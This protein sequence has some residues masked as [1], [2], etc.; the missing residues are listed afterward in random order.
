MAYEN[1]MAKP[2]E[3]LEA[4]YTEAVGKPTGEQVS[5]VINLTQSLTGETM[6]ETDKILH[7]VSP[8]RKGKVADI[9]A[10]AEASASKGITLKAELDSQV[11]EA[12]DLGIE[13]Q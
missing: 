10:L 4:K 9:L 7:I 8:V 5:R 13:S 2:F 3:V 11:Y 12:E 6:S 1:L